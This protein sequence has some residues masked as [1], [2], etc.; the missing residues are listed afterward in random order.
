MLPKF[1]GTQNVR[2]YFSTFDNLC[3]VLGCHEQLRRAYLISRL[4]GSAQAWWLGLEDTDLLS[5]DA[6]RALLM[7]HFQGEKSV[8]GRRL[9]A[10]KFGNDLGKFNQDFLKLSSAARPH[11]G[12][13]W[14]KEIYL[15]AVKPTS[16][17]LQLRGFSGE[18]LG[19]LMARA[20][21]LE[22]YYKHT[23]QAQNP[24]RVKCEKCGFWHDRNGPCRTAAGS[25]SGNNPRG[26]S[27]TNGAPR[28][29]PYHAN[30]AGLD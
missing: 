17:A 24:G 22:P 30:E 16:L 19:R 15:G 6:I 4:E 5:Y 18:K 13:E 12:D 11:M 1:D 23:P 20:E 9:Q 2:G 10:L 14:I 7:D 27:A 21:D 25:Q 29:R 28:R 8:H 26:Q 3:D